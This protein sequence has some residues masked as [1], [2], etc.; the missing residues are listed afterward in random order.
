MVHP[1]ALLVLLAVV[2]AVASPA[3]AYT[4]VSSSSFHR[5]PPSHLCTH[6]SRGIV[7]DVQCGRSVTRIIRTTRFSCVVQGGAGVAE[8][9]TAGRHL[10]ATLQNATGLDP[11]AAGNSILLALLCKVNLR[12]L[13][14]GSLL[15]LAGNMLSFDDNLNLYL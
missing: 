2:V 1:A 12:A 8:T 9:V 13:C 4:Q 10:L 11:I 3:H 15:A 7:V 6:H 5:Q 14:S